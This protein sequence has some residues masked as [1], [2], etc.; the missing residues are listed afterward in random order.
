MRRL[1]IDLN[2]RDDAGRTPA[3]YYGPTPRIGEQVVVFEP[4]DSVRADGVV[5]DVDNDRCV[6]YVAV[7]WITLTDDDQ[8]SSAAEV[9]VKVVSDFGVEGTLSVEPVL[10]RWASLA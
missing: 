1:Q 6:A 7:D 3:P 4:E 8:T 5:E 9:L 2:Q 10:G